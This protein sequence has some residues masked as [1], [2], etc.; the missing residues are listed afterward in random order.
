MLTLVLRSSLNST[1]SGLNGP[2]CTATLQVAFHSHD[3]P[4]GGYLTIYFLEAK[5]QALG[6]TIFHFVGCLSV[7]GHFVY[8]ANETITGSQCG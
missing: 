2:H 8:T 6:T 4:S 3:M 5:D 7:A 1:A